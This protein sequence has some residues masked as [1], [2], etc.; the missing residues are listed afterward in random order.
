MML[1]LFLI[2]CKLNLCHS[3]KG[4]FTMLILDRIE[5]QVAYITTDSG[6]LCVDLRL[7][8]QDVSEGSVLCIQN[9]LYVSDPIA[10]HARQAR[11]RQLL[12]DRLHAK[13]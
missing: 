12:H 11:I 5:D 9:H 2:C 10:T 3:A 7:L 4:D 8:A 1:Q 13:K 6:M